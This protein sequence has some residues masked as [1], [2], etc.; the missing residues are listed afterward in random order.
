MRNC[1]KSKSKFF[2]APINKIKKK[3]IYIYIYILVLIYS[4]H[5]YGDIITN[6]S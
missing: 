2:L 6:Y 4:T 1:K 5:C 3:K